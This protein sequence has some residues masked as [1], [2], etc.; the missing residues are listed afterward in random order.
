MIKGQN[1]NIVVE[2][3]SFIATLITFGLGFIMIRKTLSKIVAYICEVIINNV[4]EKHKQTNQ[5]FIDYI[6]Q[7]RIKSFEGIF[8]GVCSLISLFLISIILVIYRS[9]GEQIYKAYPRVIFTHDFYHKLS[10]ILRF[11]S[12]LLLA[13]FVL[14]ILLIAYQIIKD[15]K[16]INKEIRFYY[17]ERE[18]NEYLNNLLS[19]TTIS[20]EQINDILLKH[21]LGLID[22]SSLIKIREYCLSNPKT[23]ISNYIL[24]QTTKSDINLDDLLAAY[25][26]KKN[27]FIYDTVYLQIK[28]NFMHNAQISAYELNDLFEEIANKAI[29]VTPDEFALKKM[30]LMNSMVDKGEKI[31]DIKMILEVI[32]DKGII[33]K[34]EYKLKLS[35]YRNK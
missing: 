24:T 5:S 6:C 30:H 18:T 17:H 7:L 13:I 20:L 26:L 19:S 12:I 14:F 3:G 28:H 34:E 22:D 16:I 1:L 4:T 15:N 2:I 31:K 32:Q 8:I 35:Q 10:S 23:G 21:Y 33:S 25:E 29:D 9:V 27:G 11:S